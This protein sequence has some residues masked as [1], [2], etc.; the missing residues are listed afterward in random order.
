MVGIR[1]EQDRSQ[2]DVWVGANSVVVH[3][4]DETLALQYMMIRMLIACYNFALIRNI[5]VVVRNSRRKTSRL[6]CVEGFDQIFGGLCDV[7]VPII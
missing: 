6:A 7:S 4:G 1:N 2:P 5:V 3:R